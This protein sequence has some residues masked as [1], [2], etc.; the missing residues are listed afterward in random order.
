MHH[1]WPIS[2]LFYTDKILNAQ[3][4]SFFIRKSMAFFFFN[5]VWKLVFWKMTSQHV[6]FDLC[7]GISLDFFQVFLH[8]EIF[9]SLLISWNEVPRII[10]LVVEHNTWDIINFSIISSISIDIRKKIMKWHGIGVRNWR[11]EYHVY[12]ETNVAITWLI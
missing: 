6:I 4:V 12:R 11:L 1:E 5:Y 7:G 10:Q 2:L 8:R 3:N 9:F